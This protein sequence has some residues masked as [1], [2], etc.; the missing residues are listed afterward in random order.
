MDREQSWQVI[1]EQR[2]GLARLLEGL[3]DSEWEQPSLCAGWRVRDVAAHVA[4]APQV[5]GLA[6]DACRRYPGARE[7]SPTQPRCCRPPRR[8]THARHRC[9]AAHARGFSP[10]TGGDELPQHPLRC[11]RPHSGH[12]DPAGPGLSDAIRGC[13]GRCRPSVDDGMA[14]LGP[15]PPTRRA[16]WSPPTL[17]GPPVQESNFGVRSGCFCCC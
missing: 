1:T 11:A 13:A 8:P 9:R 5:P 14:V 4:M 17:T 15:P 7:L 2:L 10:V 6:V 12:R 3:S 16:C